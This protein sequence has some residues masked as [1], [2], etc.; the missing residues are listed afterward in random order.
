LPTLAVR[1]INF[2]PFKKRKERNMSWIDKDT[3]SLQWST[4]DVKQQLIDRNK[5]EKLNIE[6]C[7]EVLDRCLRRHDATMGLSWD[8]MDIHI[9]DVLEERGTS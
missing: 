3:I 2:E 6:E 5:K 9:D 1:L 4:L 8:I 7:R